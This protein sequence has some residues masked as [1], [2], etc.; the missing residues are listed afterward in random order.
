MTF[1]V[2]VL[3]PV[4]SWP[5][6]TTVASPATRKGFFGIAFRIILWL[7]LLVLVAGTLAFLWFYNG[8]RSALPQLDGTISVAGLPAPLTV[9]RGTPGR[10]DNTAAQR[11][12]PFF[13]PG[14]CPAR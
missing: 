6:S 12:E 10:P 7:L 11:E 1:V 5:M 3:V 14:H 9:G 8:A 2:F 4:K 13:A